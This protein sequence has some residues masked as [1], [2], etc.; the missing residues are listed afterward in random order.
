MLIGGLQKTSLI[1]YPG[2][3]ACTVFTI[4]CNFFCPF[5]HNKDLVS[6]ANFKN[7]SLAVVKEKDFFDFLSKRGGILDGVCITGGEPTI[8]P[9]LMQFCQKIKKLGFLVKLDTNGGRPRVVKELIKKRLVDFIAM[10]IKVDKKN[11]SLLT[12]ISYEKIAQSLVLIIT[13][14]LEY[15][16]RT[17]LVPT[18]HNKKNIAILAKEI[19]VVATKNKI[20]PES[21]VWHLQKFLPQNCLKAEF[22]QFLPFSSQELNCLLTAAQS[23]IPQVDADF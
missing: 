9:G 4:G 5:C 11:Y 8:Q 15:Q 7:S 10:D 12:K 13:S 18:I 14:G 16:L 1:D 22:D 2:K 19:A 6:W 21:L 17:T 23:I 3:V 20:N